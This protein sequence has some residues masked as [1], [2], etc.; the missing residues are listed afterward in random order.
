MNR[1]LPVYSREQRT[2][3]PCL[4]GYLATAARVK[5]PA[6][7]QRCKFDGPLLTAGALIISAGGGLN[8]EFKEKRIFSRLPDRTPAAD[9]RQKCSGFLWQCKFRLSDGCMQPCSC[10][11]LCSY[12]FH[13]RNIIN[14][15]SQFSK[16]ENRVRATRNSRLYKRGWQK[17]AKNKVDCIF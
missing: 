3:Y 6:A 14:V 16:G 7:L 10:M 4:H 2:K 12:T 15:Q 1:R 13:N 11:Q 17:A 9:D 8:G 5:C